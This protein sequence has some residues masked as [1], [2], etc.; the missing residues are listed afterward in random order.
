M[1]SW[2]W[3]V[4]KNVS[5][6]IPKPINYFDLA[7]NMCKAK[8]AIQINPSILF[9]VVEYTSDCMCMFGC[10]CKL[11]I[12]KTFLDML[13]YN[14][15]IK[16]CDIVYIPG[17][18]W[19]KLS[20]KLPLSINTLVNN[21]ATVNW[22]KISSSHLYKKNLQFIN[23]FHMHI[24][25]EQLDNLSDIC[26][27]EIVD[28]TFTRHIIPVDITISKQLLAPS[29]YNDYHEVLTPHAFLIFQ[30]YKLEDI[31]KYN[32]PWKS[33]EHIEHSD[34][35]NNEDKYHDVID[36]YDGGAFAQKC[37][38]ERY[39]P[40][41][42]DFIVAL[43]YS[44]TNNDW[45]KF[46]GN[47]Q[48][49]E[50]FIDKYIATNASKLTWDIISGKYINLYVNCFIRYEKTH[51]LTMSFINKFAT[52]LNWKYLVTCK[53]CIDQQTLIKYISNVDYET[54]CKY[55]IFDPSYIDKHAN[56][57]CWYTMCEFQKLPEWLMRK[58]ID[59]LNWGQV[60][61]Y[62]TMSSAFICEFKSS[63]NHVR[64]LRNTKINYIP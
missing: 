16:E 6:N 27:T 19:F 15:T 44:I 54:Q 29:E 42:K 53:K 33:I 31:E 21:A 23:S 25:W 17:I 35:E 18:D 46:I 36:E 48:P 43:Q 55:I 49:D 40:Q 12:P 50:A 37:I 2:D 38:H 13:I 28:L 11:D 41:T 26:A 1:E 59:K 24:V 39:I 60:S 4:S 63:L 30:N 5:I 57:L 8:L 3:F 64:L 61:E 45:T 22:S 10:D 51:Q 9:H 58:H 52:K 20:D 14:K 47:C 56:V 7:K 34:D 32:L 62:Q